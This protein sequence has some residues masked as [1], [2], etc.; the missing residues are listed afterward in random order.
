MREKSG[1]W[2]GCRV[3][4]DVLDA[5][6]SC[7]EHELDRDSERPPTFAKILVERAGQVLLVYDRDRER[8]ELPGG[9]M[10]PGETSRMAAVR[11]LAEETGIETEKLIFVAGLTIRAADGRMLRGG[12]FRTI[13][14]GDDP[15]RTFQPSDEI[16]ALRWSEPATIERQLTAEVVR[17]TLAIDPVDDPGSITRQTYQAAAEAYARRTP[18]RG[19]DEFLDRVV[20]LM[21]GAEVLEIGSGPG[22]DADHLEVRG[23]RVTRTDVTP[24]FVDALRAA[25]HQARTLDVRTDDL[26]GP[27]DVILA[28][29]VLLHLTR[30]EFADAVTRAR[31]AVRPGGLLAISLKEG[32]GERWSEAKLELPRYFVYWR[33][34]AVRDVL[35]Q[36]GWTIEHLDHRQR[37]EP[38]LM[39]IAR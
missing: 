9:G 32:D 11:E 38:W 2:Q 16:A 28:N 27:W 21:P 20:E 13:L 10:E 31:A 25:G 18:R 33:E 8:W 14:T 4:A 37:S 34:P 19:P 6:D 5:F 30:A 12:L 22:W 24:A 35:E 1:D 36:A 17:R 7:A 23:C 29:A 3:T 39:I 15:T 26:G